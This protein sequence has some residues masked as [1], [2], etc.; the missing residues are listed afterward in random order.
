[1]EIVA[2]KDV[3]TY[4]RIFDRYAIDPATFVMVG[5]SVRSDILPVRSLGGHAVHIEYELLWE[6]EHAEGD[7]DLDGYWELDTIR[8]LPELIARL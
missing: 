4:R 3:A 7:P 6:M 8:D 2:E 1:V 5:N